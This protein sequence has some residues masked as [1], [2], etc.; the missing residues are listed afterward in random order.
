MVTLARLRSV[1]QR[2]ALTQ[3]ELAEKAG[4]NRVTIARLEGGVDE[5]RPATLRKLAAAL[6]VEPANLM[7]RV[8][9]ADASGQAHRR[10]GRSSPSVP[11]PQP[12]PRSR[13]APVDLGGQL[14]VAE[15][16]RVRRV[17]K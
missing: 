12:S 10:A 11:K 2:K 6:G 4:V 17:L 5:P 9:A 1:R 16:E 8:T 15:D 3:Q 13:Q 14:E 7:G